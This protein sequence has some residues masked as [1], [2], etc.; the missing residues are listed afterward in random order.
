M[1]EGRHCHDPEG[2]IRI[3]SGDDNAALVL[4]HG[5]VAGEEQTGVA[6]QS[7]GLLGEDGMAGAENPM[8]GC[9]PPLLPERLLDVN[10]RQHPESLV[11]QGSAHGR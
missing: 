3:Q 6:L 5:D 2:R 11:S 4:I 7:E 8:E 10:L 9:Q 1:G